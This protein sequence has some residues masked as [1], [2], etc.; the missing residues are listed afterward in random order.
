MDWA[1]VPVTR[2]TGVTPA[3]AAWTASAGTCVAVGRASAASICQPCCPRAAP[4][5][6]LQIRGKGDASTCGKDADG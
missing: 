5:R 6:P 3:T 2:V 4:T 1:A